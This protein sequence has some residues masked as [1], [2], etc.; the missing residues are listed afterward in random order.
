MRIAAL[1]FL[2][3]ALIAGFGVWWVAGDRQSFTVVNDR[4]S[5]VYVWATLRSCE[6]GYRYEED[7]LRFEPVRSNTSRAYTHRSSPVLGG[8]IECV[9]VIDGGSQF[10]LREPYE[11]GQTYV[12]TSA[13]EPAGYAPDSLLY[14]PLSQ[15]AVMFSSLIWPFVIATL[16][17]IVAGL[18]S[19][20]R[21][22]SWLDRKK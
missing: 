9:H 22:A 4:D 18:I 16:V 13:M 11:A 1:L 19:L 5:D 2:L 14:R 20:Y 15:T 21:F 6:D 10:L 7:R 8:G 17:G 3:S 12:V